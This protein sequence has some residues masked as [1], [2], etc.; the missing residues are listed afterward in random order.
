MPEWLSAPDWHVENGKARVT[1]QNKVLTIAPGIPGG[2]TYRFRLDTDRAVRVTMTSGQICYFD[3]YV[4]GNQVF[5]YADLNF[6]F[7]NPRMEVVETID[8]VTFPV[9]VELWGAGSYIGGK[10]ND[11]IFRGVNFASGV[12]RFELV[13]GSYAEL[14]YLTVDE[15]NG[16]TLPDGSP[17]KPNC[18]FPRQW[19]PFEIVDSITVDMQTNPVTPYN[20]VP[21]PCGAVFAAQQR[22]GVFVLDYVGVKSVAT[23]LS[24]FAGY[25]VNIFTPT[26]ELEGDFGCGTDTMRLCFWPGQATSPWGSTHGGLIQVQFVGNESVGGVYEVS[27]FWDTA[28]F[29]WGYG[30]G[31]LPTDLGPTGSIGYWTYGTNGFVTGGTFTVTPNYT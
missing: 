28:H 2:S 25:P 27:Q 1:S 3:F 20:N 23:H 15:N 9:D 30:P 22:T 31:V 24:P 10:F 12:P 13:G 6:N 11:R 8:G 29:F 19:F 14:D 5:F 7:L 4:P 21:N 17:I 18:K 16:S 26:F